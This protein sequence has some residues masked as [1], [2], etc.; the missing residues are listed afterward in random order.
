MGAQD[1]EHHAR[2]LAYPDAVVAL[3]LNDVAGPAT[4]GT[5]PSAP[6]NGTASP[7]VFDSGTHRAAPAL[8]PAAGGICTQLQGFLSGTLDSIVQ[9]LQIDAQEGVGG[10]LASIWNTVISIAASAAKLVVEALTAPVM[11][12][13]RA[14][15]TLLAVLSSASSL[16]DPWAVT[17]TA[18][19][20]P[21]H[22]GIG[23]TGNDVTVT[24]SVASAIDFSWPT[25]VQDCAA[26]ANVT[27][28]DPGSAQGSP[29]TWKV[30]TDPTVATM[31]A[32]DATVGSDGKARL[33][34]TTGVETSDDHEHGDLVV[35]PVSV[36]T[37]LERTQIGNLLDL[38][39]SVL[40]DALPSP[41]HG[42][43]AQLLGPLKSSTQAKLQDL[44]S[45]HGPVTWIT[46]NHHGPAGP[47]AAPSPTAT[48]ADCPTAGTAVI[49]DGTWEGPIT[50]DVTGVA[51]V[52]TTKSS[53]S[54]ELHALVQGGKVVQGT[55]HVAWHSVGHGATNGAEAT[56]SLDA[57]I[58][59]NVKGPAA[60]PVVHGAWSLSGTAKVTK[61]VTATVP[62]AESG[63][64]TETM[65]VEATD[66]DAVTGTFVPSFN[67]KNSMASFSG[68]AR[69]VGHRVD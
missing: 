41:V 17:T 58:A 24:S 31:G 23:S 36:S 1:F 32:K 8:L 18:D 46:V 49:P 68:T 60:K 47:S 50:L 43:V 16:L 37:D 57:E 56:V 5:A 39:Q 4:P 33:H 54:G 25:D 35:T 30:Q 63:Q 2:E 29:V 44:V 66:C 67:S 61:P 6:S 48:A 40:L 45:V 65:T 64:D 14:A 22:F 59:G 9:A 26:A 19:P 52:A 7:A 28:P 3:F 42:I 15:A 11:K 13:I 69:W 53:G 20:D 10:V 34:L 21:V 55:W 62:I 38:V 51:G 27:L 12:A